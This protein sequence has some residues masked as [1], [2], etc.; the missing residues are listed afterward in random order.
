MIDSK[1]IRLRGGHSPSEGYI[2]IKR[3]GVWGWFCNT[4]WTKASADIACKELGFSLGAVK[5]ATSFGG[6]KYGKS[7]NLGIT[8]VGTEKSLLEC[9]ASQGR[10]RYCPTAGAIC[11][12]GDTNQIKGTIFYIV[13]GTFSGV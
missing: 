12:T 4:N 1:T 7:L 6:N 9:T 2:E 8:C 13:L 5:T 3:D 10:S 11:K